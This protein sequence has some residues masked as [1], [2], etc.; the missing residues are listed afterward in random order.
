MNRAG[1][2]AVSDDGKPVADA[3]LMRHALEY[4]RMFDRAVLSHCEDVE[5]ARG[6]APSSPDGYSLLT[7]RCG[8][9][10]DVSFTAS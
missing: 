6:G 3:G 9:A 10:C 4:C 7:I 2:V 5:L 1:I 8:S